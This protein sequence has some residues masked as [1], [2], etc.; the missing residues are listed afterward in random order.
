VDG[1]LTPQPHV[2]LSDAEREGVLARLRAAAGEGRITLDEFQERADGVLRAQ[3]YGEIAVYVAD[4]PA[5]PAG[6]AAP[7]RELLEIRS[8]ATSLRRRG[9]W[10]VPRRLLVHAK[11]G[12]VKLDFT[13][14]VIATP[15]VD[16][17][18]DVVA[19]STTLVL[20][21]GATADA[22]GV[23]MVAGSLKIRGVPSHPDPAAGP[24]IVVTGEQKAGSLT[25]RHLR[26]FWRWWW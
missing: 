13:E 14:A 11:A 8:T 26:H 24:H 7:V 2:R 16:V 4:L 21:V 1:E 23:H 18:L 12:S 6:P 3:T 5:G 22:D 9:R 10:T 20:P 15:V 25:V 19:G 17:V